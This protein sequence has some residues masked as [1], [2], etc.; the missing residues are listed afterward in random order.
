MFCHPF[1][2][3]RVYIMEWCFCRKGILVSQFLRWHLSESPKSLNELL[4]CLLVNI[5]S[6]EKFLEIPILFLLKVNLFSFSL[7]FIAFFISETT[8]KL[9]SMYLGCQ[10]WFLFSHFVCN[11]VN[12][13]SF[14][15]FPCL[16]FTLP[17]VIISIA[18]LSL[19]AGTA[20]LC[21]VLQI[22]FNFCVLFFSFL[23]FCFI[24]VCPLY[25]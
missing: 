18:P 17:F 8:I 9:T 7:E 21:L 13:L 14:Q 25:H 4:H 22:T 10:K 19:L 6:G 5:V 2:H 12:S 3:L 15:I 20:I 1:P 11:L 16:F 24:F 23:I